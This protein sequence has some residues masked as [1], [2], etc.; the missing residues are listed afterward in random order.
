M[1]LQYIRITTLY[2]TAC[3]LITGL[4]FTTG[5]RKEKAPEP[6]NLDK[7]YFVVEDNPNDP[8]D[9]AI[10]EF[11]KSTGIPGYC[12][13][14][15][16]K[17][18]VSRENEHPVRYKYITLSLS[19]TPLGTS[20]LNTMPLTSR[21]GIPALLN[22]LKTE[23]IPKLP[24]VRLFPAILFL[25]SFSAYLNTNVQISQGW[26]ALMGFNSLGVVAKDVEVMSTAERKIYA[27]SILAGIGEKRIN[28]LMATRVLK[29]FLSISREATK[30]MLPNDLDIYIGWPFML[31]MPPGW[32][33]PPQDLGFLF[34]P[35]ISVYGML[36]NNTL[37]QTDDIRGYLTAVF[38]YTNEEFAALH[39]NETLVLKKFGIMRNFAKEAGFKIPE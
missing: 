39:A 25:D 30:D 13:D 20:Y 29:E 11:Y 5:C 8:V 23:V 10:F 37:M 17:E 4:L 7:N 16:Y 12:S 19:Y 15:I 26:T 24:P 31:F 22:L 34:Y 36:V 3:I 1:K 28:D 9:H 6:S 21:E 14:T 35:Q 27:A 2:T 32:E 38:C 18:K 33:P